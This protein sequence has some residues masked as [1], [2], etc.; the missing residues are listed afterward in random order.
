MRGE[1]LRS[2]LRHFHS[3][4]TLPE[5][6]PH[7]DE[8][9]VEPVESSERWADEAPHRGPDVKPVEI[10]ERGSNVKPVKVPKRGSFQDPHG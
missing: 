9:D 6:K 7:H 3:S 4:A 10:S 8:P 2:L 1:R 5:R